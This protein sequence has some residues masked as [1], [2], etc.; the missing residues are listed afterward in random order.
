MNRDN[1]PLLSTHG[2]ELA[3]LLKAGNDGLTEIWALR[4]RAGRT[5]D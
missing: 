4:T 2:T 5:Y 1:K 3:G